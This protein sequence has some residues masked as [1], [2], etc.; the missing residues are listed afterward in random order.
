MSC[1]MVILRGSNRK[2]QNKKRQVIEFCKISI[3]ILKISI[4]ILTLGLF[5]PFYKKEKNH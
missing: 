3:E 4:E 2:K 5:E 1:V